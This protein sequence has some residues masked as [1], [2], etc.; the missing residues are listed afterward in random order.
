MEHRAVTSL[1][2]V[3]VELAHTPLPLPSSTAAGEEFA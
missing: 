1:V 3:T 2:D